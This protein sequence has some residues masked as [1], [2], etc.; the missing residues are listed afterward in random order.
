MGKPIF[1]GK[2]C[3]AL[4]IANLQLIHFL[5]YVDQVNKILDVMGTPVV[6]LSLIMTNTHAQGHRPNESCHLL[7]ANE[8]RRTFARCRS[9][10]R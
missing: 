6:S 3:V 8:R 1:K 2:E 7:V 4:S 10:S 5:S 9:R